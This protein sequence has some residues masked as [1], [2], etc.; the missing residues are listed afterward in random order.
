[1]TAVGAL[2]AVGRNILSSTVSQ[3]FGADLRQDLFTKVQ[4][5]SLDDLSRFEPASLITRLTNDVTQVQEFVHRLM[6]IFVRA[7]IL[8]V[9]AA[10]MAIYLNPR[11]ST[12]LAVVIP[13]VG[14]LVALNLQI[15]FPRFRR[16]QE[17]VDGINRSKEYLR[18]RREG[19]QPQSVRARAI[20]RRQ[21]GSC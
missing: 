11:L 19:L 13:V 21:S 4:L 8:A 5:L 18:R 10:A 16:V 6:R 14:L 7:P 12:I 1:M 3:N 9:G 20:C 17:A 2:G 15:G